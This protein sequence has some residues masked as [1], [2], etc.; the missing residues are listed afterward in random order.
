MNILP[1][2]LLKISLDLTSSALLSRR[3]VSGWR[4]AV[5][6]AF[7]NVSEDCEAA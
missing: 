3:A 5:R 7:N 4:M 2:E 6:Q 1:R